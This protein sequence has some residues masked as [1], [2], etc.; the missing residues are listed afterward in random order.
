MSFFSKRFYQFPKNVYNFRFLGFFFFDVKLIDSLIYLFHVLSLFNYSVPRTTIVAQ[1]LISPLFLY[2]GTKVLFLYLSSIHF[3]SNR[4]LNNLVSY[5]IFLS[6]TH[7]NFNSTSLGP[8]NFP[9]S[10]SFLVAFLTYDS[11]ILP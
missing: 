1:F 4:L 5:T 10:H 2:I 7:S 3:V 6:T 11:V 8:T 9:F